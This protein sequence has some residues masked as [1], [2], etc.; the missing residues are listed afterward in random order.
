MTTETINQVTFN[1]KEFNPDKNGFYFYN[2]LKF[3]YRSF[4]KYLRNELI[5]FYVNKIE[6]EVLK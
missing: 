3:K 6:R 4:C 5:W 2:G 1:F